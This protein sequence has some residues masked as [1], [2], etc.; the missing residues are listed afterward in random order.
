MELNVL[1]G[2]VN[3]KR[4]N[5]SVSECQ[6]S[7]RYYKRNGRVEGAPLDEEVRE[8]AKGNPFN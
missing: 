2:E 4:V 5:D 3:N 7:Q 8:A 6:G 1:A